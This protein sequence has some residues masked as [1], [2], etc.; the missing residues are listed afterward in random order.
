[1]IARR[2]G[3][4]RFGRSGGFISEAAEIQ[5]RDSEQTNGN[6]MATISILA[7]S[8][9]AVA[10]SSHSKIGI[11]LLRLTPTPALFNSS[12]APAASS[13]SSS[14]GGGGDDEAAF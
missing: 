4:P 2:R 8:L 1:M 14:S 12:P 10:A 5:M 7:G 11:C 9:P 3:Q 6:C 13:R